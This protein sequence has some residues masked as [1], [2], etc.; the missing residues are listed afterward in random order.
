[1]HTF[2]VILRPIITEKTSDGTRGRPAWVR[3]AL[4]VTASSWSVVEDQSAVLSTVQLRPDR[5]RTSRK[6]FWRRRPLSLTA[7]Q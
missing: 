1:M 4:A 7:S 3:A 6:G 5:E 2:D